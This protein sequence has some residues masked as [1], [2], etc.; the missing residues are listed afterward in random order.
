VASLRHV[1]VTRLMHPQQYS[2]PEGH[3]QLVQTRTPHVRESL[4]FR[5]GR[6][7]VVVV[8]VCFVAFEIDEP[9]RLQYPETKQSS[10]HEPLVALLEVHVEILLQDG[11]QVHEK[12][13]ESKVNSD[14]LGIWQRVARDQQGERVQAQRRPSEEPRGAVLTPMFREHG[15]LSG[16][17]VNKGELGS[18]TVVLEL[19]F[20]KHG[21]KGQVRQHKE[22]LVL[23]VGHDQNQHM[24]PREQ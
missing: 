2:L 1:A 14:C 5:T 10:R 12:Q 11:L 17:V 3:G 19:V 18:Q 6:D 22:Q 4:D 24:T 23:K 9:A 20:H 13:P 21:V 8:M 16:L 7:L 15:L